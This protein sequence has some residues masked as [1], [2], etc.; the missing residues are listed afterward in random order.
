MPTTMDARDKPKR[1]G[2]I[3]RV[4]EET[5][6]RRE[7]GDWVSDSQ[8]IGENPDLMPELERE[9]RILAVVEDA[10]RGGKAITP[11]PE[12]HGQG[13]GSTRPLRT[14]V[15]GLIDELIEGYE[16]RSRV[17]SGAQGMVYEAVQIAT[18]R[19]VAIKV[20]RDGFH[21]DPRQ[22]D[23]FRREVEIL[24][25]LD[26][27]NIVGV[28]D[29]GV[30]RGQFYY[31]MDYID[32]VTLDRYMESANLGVDQT[33]RLFEKIAS[34]VNAAHLR[35]V[36]HRD[37]KPANILVD[38][39]GEPRLLDFGLARFERGDGRD[40]PG[41][42]SGHL[43]RTGQFVGSLP[44]TS[45]EQAE[46]VASRIDLRTDV[47]SLGVILFQMLTGKLPY[48]VEPEVAAAAVT[49][50]TSDVPRPSRLRKGISEDVDTIVLKCMQKEPSVRYQSAGELAAD[51]GRCIERKPLMAQPQ[52]WRARARSFVRRYRVFV[53]VS[54]AVFILLVTALTLLA[55]Y[56]LRLE[57]KLAPP[58]SPSAGSA[59]PP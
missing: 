6:A 5:M 57:A 42:S 24:A 4:I 34:A 18:G 54:A 14:A 41:G 10:R 17:H 39:Y 33:M 35:G 59:S 43:T 26:H 46:G 25:L 1:A 12:G 20:R 7:A 15:D 56:A 38:T 44:W 27:A 49:I 3:R 58:Q 47:Y 16:I 19:R 21:G 51:V 28:I 40:A 30:G 23:R 48:E 2:K 50:G 11:L 13:S 55:A 31:V 8:V 37:L 53:S 45:P 9:L 22:H 52:G 29:S 36:I 32:G